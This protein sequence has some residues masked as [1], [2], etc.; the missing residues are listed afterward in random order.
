MITDA[1]GDAATPVR[2]PDH[3]LQLL[4]GEFGLVFP[5]GTRFSQPAF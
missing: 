1:A 5:A 3:L 2:D 4:A